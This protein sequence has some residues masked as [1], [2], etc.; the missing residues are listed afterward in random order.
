MEPP[1]TK[2]R[3][4]S[5]NLVAVIPSRSQTHQ[6]PNSDRLVMISSNHSTDEKQ[7][8]APQEATPPHPTPKITLAEGDVTGMAN[9]TPEKMPHVTSSAAIAPGCSAQQG[10]R[11]ETQGETDGWVRTEIQK[12]GCLWKHTQSRSIATAT[13]RPQRAWCHGRINPAWLCLW[14]GGWRVRPHKWPHV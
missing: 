10:G 6:R 1:S 4:K 13:V 2:Q 5:R 9:G 11:R 12:H 8:V 7:I 14:A 3:F